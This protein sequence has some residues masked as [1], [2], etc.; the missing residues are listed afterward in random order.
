V[1]DEST[2]SQYLEI[3][4]FVLLD[5]S[6]VGTYSMRAY[7]GTDTI[8]ININALTEVSDSLADVNNS[9]LAGDTI[10]VMLGV[11]GQYDTSSTAPYLSG[12]YITPMYFTDLTIC[13]DVTIGIA[14]NAEAVDNLTFYPNPTTGSFTIATTG[15]END[16]AIIT[17]RDISGKV[18]VRE[19]IINSSSAFKKHYSLEGQ[20]KGLYL[21]SIIDGEKRIN[22]KLILQ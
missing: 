18:I 11:G 13:K 4:K 21:I 20:A 17:I 14:K 5:S 12:Y 16:N 2:E 6:G 8:A 15:L 1:L 10:C 22:K 19:N 3:E 7:N 9:L